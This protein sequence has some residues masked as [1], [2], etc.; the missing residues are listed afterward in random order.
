MSLE[1]VLREASK[2]ADQGYVG[3]KSPSGKRYDTVFGR[4]YPM[5]HQ[6]FCDMFV[7]YCASVGGEAAA[8]GKFAYCPSHVNY[9]KNKGRWYGRTATFKRGDVV[10]FSWDGGPTADH[11]GFVL[12]DSAPGQSVKT[13]EGNTVA[14]SGPNQGS[15]GAVCYK[16]RPRNVILGVGRPAYGSTGTTGKAVT[17]DG[18][19]YG[20]GATGDHITVM[21]R[22]LVKAGCSKYKEGPGPTWGSADTESFRAYQIKIGD[23]GSAADGIPGPKQL[24][25]LLKE[26]GGSTGST[27]KP[28]TKKVKLKRGQTLS[29]I[30]AAAGISLAALLALN[31]TVKNPDKVQEGQEITVPAA[32]ATPAKPAPTTPA[33]P[34]PTTPA[35]PKPTTPAKPSGGAVTIDGKKY[36]PG[37]SGSHITT[38]GQ[39]LVKR[40]F[41]KNYKQGPGPNWTEADRLNYQAYQKSLGFTGK[42][43]DGI[44]GPVTLRKLLSTSKAVKVAAA[45]QRSTVVV[46]AVARTVQVGNLDAWIAQAREE[47]RKNGDLV[48]SA[49]AIKARVMVESGGN[50]RAINLHDSNAAKG[51]PSKGLIQTIDPTFQAYRLPQLANDP[52]DPVSNIVAGVRYANAAYGSFESIAY[53]GGGY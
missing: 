37:A 4:W 7:S 8:V 30:A 2:W 36:G 15:G 27:A 35:K 48:P 24:A 51:T 28:S 19:K 14:G 9:F 10:F 39:A 20:P 13:V 43:A 53:R 17:I 21:G 6:P 33:K 12:A 44:P 23:G 40:G 11:V 52:F 41:G 22:A 46:Q 49:E 25:K 5:S 50:P 31:P 3:G 18:K 16:T 32:P 45:P 29:A 47:L 38:M 26:Y 42:D 1:A 34:K